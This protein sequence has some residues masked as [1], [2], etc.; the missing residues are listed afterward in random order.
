[1][2][3]GSDRGTRQNRGDSA[4]KPRGPFA[5]QGRPPPISSREK[6]DLFLL[7]GKGDG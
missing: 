6:N 1:M 5:S 4:V 2:A 3:R 7:E